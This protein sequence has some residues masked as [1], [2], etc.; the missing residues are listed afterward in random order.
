MNIF[1]FIFAVICVI[2]LGIIALVYLAGKYN[3]LESNKKNK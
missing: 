2:V 3:M 1:E